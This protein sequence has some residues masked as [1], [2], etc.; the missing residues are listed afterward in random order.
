MSTDA[1]DAQA[2][3]DERRWVSARQVCRDFSVTSRTVR[4]WITQ[5]K[6]VGKKVRGYWYIER[7]S[8]IAH[9]RRRHES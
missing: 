3:A 9:A 1:P 8:L 6:V 7:E 4:N 5:G 2:D